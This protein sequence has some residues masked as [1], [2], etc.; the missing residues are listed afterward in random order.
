MIGAEVMLGMQCYVSSGF[1]SPSPEEQYYYHVCPLKRY[2]H[3][4]L[5]RLTNRT[6]IRSNTFEKVIKLRWR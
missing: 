3:I 4:D 6:V 5:L 1:G 2:T